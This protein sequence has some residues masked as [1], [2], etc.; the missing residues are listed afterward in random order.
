L[1]DALSRIGYTGLVLAK[2]LGY[3]LG[4]S[5]VIDESSMV[6]VAALHVSCEREEVEVQYAMLSALEQRVEDEN[7]PKAKEHQS[8]SEH[9]ATIERQLCPQEEHARNQ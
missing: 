7:R 4:I 6:D 9:H 2:A 3:A 8:N 1:E 5:R